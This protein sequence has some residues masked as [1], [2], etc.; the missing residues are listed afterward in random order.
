MKTVETLYES[1]RS[2]IVLLGLVEL[3]WIGYWLST[4][5]AG[6]GYLLLLFLWVCT[7]M[8]WLWLVISLARNKFIETHSFKFTNL[9]GFFTV[10]IFSI[11][12]FGSTETGR[13]GI[14]SAVQQ[15]SDTQLILIHTLRILSFGTFIKYLQGQ[16]PGHFI[17]LG[18][19]PD[20]CFAL[21]AIFLLFVDTSV[22]NDPRFYLMWHSVGIAAFF[23]AGISMFFSVPSPIQITSKLPNTSLVFRYPMALA[24]NFC[25]PLFALAH[26]FALVKFI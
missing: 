8:V 9:I 22:S 19:I 3:A 17:L 7:M 20:F 23:G 21:T 16:L 26:I 14:Q 25:V 11:L 24:P 18:T 15:M 2:L 5:T 6:I 12:V 13:S 4:A 10:I 1:S